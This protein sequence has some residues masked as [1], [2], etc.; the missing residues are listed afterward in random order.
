M[1]ARTIR[2]VRLKRVGRSEWEFL[3]DYPP[4]G[5]GLVRRGERHDFNVKR[6]PGIGWV[7]HE[8]DASVR[9]PEKAFLGNFEVESLE[10][11]VAFALDGG[12]GFLGRRRGQPVA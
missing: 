5:L 9:N 1:R 4:R 8:F 3:V 6:V 2:G 12:A 7:L 11:A 10:D